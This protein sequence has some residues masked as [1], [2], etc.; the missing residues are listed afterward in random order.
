MPYSVDFAKSARRHLAAAHKL[1]TDTTSDRASSRAVSGYLYGLAG[2]LALKNLM[3]RRGLAWLKQHERRD[4][5]YFA[6]FPVLKTLLRD[7]AQGRQNTDILRYAMNVT[8]FQHW[9]T[10]MRYAPTTDIDPR[11]VDQW[12]SEAEELVQVMDT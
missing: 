8:L 4:D 12:K 6:H 11:W 3:R 9:D 7:R 2:E 10:K 5:P 1:Y